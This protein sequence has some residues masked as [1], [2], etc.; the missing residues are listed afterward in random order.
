MHASREKRVIRDDYAGKVRLWVQNP[1]VVP[2]AQGP[3]LPPFSVKRFSSYE[4][5]NRWKE[6][7]IR[8]A[9]RSSNG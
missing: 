7:R 2:H 8:E 3:K 5:M 6:N 1:I 4:E 9:A